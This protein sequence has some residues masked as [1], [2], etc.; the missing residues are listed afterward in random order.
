MKQ[1][2]PCPITN[3]LD[4]ISAKWTV[5][6]L[7]ELALKPVR[8][9]EFLKVIPGL[10]MKSLQERLKALLAAGM[11]TRIVFQEKLPRVEHTITPLGRRLFG[12]MS[13]LK[14]IAAE[15]GVASVECQCPLEG[16][17]KEQMNC[18]KRREPLSPR[19]IRAEGK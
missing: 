17:G 5:E 2:A 19:Q 8:T 12:L 13:E 3:A 1:Q 9:R 15:I 6:I 14:E 7:R 16:F 4:L 11:I 10:S 18:P